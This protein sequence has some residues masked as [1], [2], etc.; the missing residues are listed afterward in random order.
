LPDL[1][2]D[3]ATEVSS[4][5]KTDVKSHNPGPSSFAMDRQPCT[6][7]NVPS[8]R[9]T[10]VEMATEGS[11][12]VKL[13]SSR[14]RAG[15]SRNAWSW[16]ARS[17]REAV[18]RET[19]STVDGPCDEQIEP[20]GFACSCDIAAESSIKEQGLSPGRMCRGSLMV[21]EADQWAMM[22]SCR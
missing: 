18:Y 8:Y 3:L 4:T 10:D 2:V 21:A 13:I 11:L 5:N 9:F 17:W 16:N 6:T 7:V 19:W 15:C 20:C 12:S 22:E 1:T 14:A